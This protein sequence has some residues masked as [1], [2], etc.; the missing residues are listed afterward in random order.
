MP[1][2]RLP[3]L[4]TALLLTLALAACGSGSPD[5][6]TGTASAVEPTVADKPAA[7]GD[8][9]GAKP[10]AE[11][12][13]QDPEFTP[14]PHQDSGGGTGQF[15]AEGGD[16]SI[17]EYGEET[18]GSDFAEAAEV[19]HVYLDARAAGAW[20]VA[21]KQL[22]AAIAGELVRQLGA[23]RGEQKPS[24]GETLAALAAAVPA[25]ALREA[26]EV[27]VG[28]LRVEGDTGFLLLRGAGDEHYFIPMRR[29]DGGWKVAG[30]AASPLL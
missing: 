2:Q 18:S 29:E 13:S 9:K 23:A 3:S 21:C 16:N 19:L 4:L 12:D 26:A 15:E 30:I 25:A 1:L 5:S 10:R 6:T 11:V 22:P 20:D 7:D 14:Q 8:D 28:A 24:C 17:Q 27:D